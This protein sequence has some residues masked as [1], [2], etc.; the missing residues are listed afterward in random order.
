MKSKPLPKRHRADTN[1]SELGPSGEPSGKDLEDLYKSIF[2]SMLY[3]AHIWR[4]VRDDHGVIKTWYLIDANPAA[5]DN[6]NQSLQEIRGKTAD[7]IFPGANATITFMPIIQ[8]MFHEKKPHSW[9][10]F[11]SGTN[12]TLK[13]VSIPLG[14]IFVS[15]G[16]DISD[17][18][19]I[20]DELKQSQKRLILA[21]EAAKVSTWEYLLASNELVWDESNYRLYGADPTTTERP[22]SIWSS[23]V[24][25]EDVEDARRDLDK[26]ISSLSSMKSEFRIVRHENSKIRYVVVQ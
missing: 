18:K 15:M 22:S 16:A 21:T 10:S 4:V 7:E 11:F 6:W 14:E 2:E 20:H 17:I 23:V 3:E 19:Q 12:Q 9:E 25:K 26:A 13:M 8:K 5:L 24:H 1:G